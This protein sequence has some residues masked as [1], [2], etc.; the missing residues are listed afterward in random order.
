MVSRTTKLLFI[1]PGVAYLAIIGLFPFF[2]SL[3]MSTHSL[4]LTRPRRNQFIGIDNYIQ[5][6]SDPLFQRA[7]LNTAI[8]AVASITLEI[9][10]GFIVAKI[11]YEIAHIRTVNLLRTLFILPMMVTPVITG[12]LFTYIFNPTLGIANYLLRT[13]G[14]PESAWFGSADVALLSIIIVN[15]WQWAPFLMLIMLAGL[16]A[17]P[18]ELYEASALDG[19]KWYEQSWNIELPAVRDVLMVG[20]IIRLIDNLRFF[21]VVYIATRGGPGDA[22]EVISM[23]AYRQ[24]F[25]FFNMGYGSAAA[26][27]ILFITLFVATIAVKYLQKAENA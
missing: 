13:L 16:M 18:R 11:F 1:G 12:L 9:I 10:I 26:I 19:A 27:L 24:S 7:I 22:T 8:L 4:N 20:I 23:F 3:Y 15:V 17:V 21:D 25:Q 6:V 2:Y 5:L 14:L